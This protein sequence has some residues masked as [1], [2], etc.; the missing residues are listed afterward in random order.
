VPDIKLLLF[1]QQQQEP[2]SIT[3][4]N[5]NTTLNNVTKPSASYVPPDSVKTTFTE[6]EIERM[7]QCGNLFDRKNVANQEILEEFFR[8]EPCLYSKYLLI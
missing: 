2:L 4:L 7:R 5:K 8:K 1:N 3:G 6:H